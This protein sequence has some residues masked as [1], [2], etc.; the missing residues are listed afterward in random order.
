M[1]KSAGILDR[2][3]LGSQFDNFRTTLIEINVERASLS[4]EIVVASKKFLS[5]QEAGV[6]YGALSARAPEITAQPNNL[7]R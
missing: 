2:I 5:G 6:N 4:Q 3:S 7:I 1:K